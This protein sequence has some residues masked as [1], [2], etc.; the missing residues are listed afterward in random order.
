MRFAI[1][2]DDTNFFTTPGELLA[3]YGAVWDRFPIT[4]SLISR[5]KGNWP[6]WVH[7]IYSQRAKTDWTA[8]LADDTA[9]PIGDNRELVDFLKDGLAQGCVDLAF[10]ARHHRNAEPDDWSPL[11]D[12]YIQGAEF[13]VKS[14][15]S[16]VLRQEVDYLNALFGYSINVFTPPQNILSQVGYESVIRADL[17]LCGGCIPFYRKE[18]SRAGLLNL[19]RQIAFRIKHPGTDY[20]YVLRYSHHSEIIH[21]YP[22]QPTTR[23]ESLVAAFERAR[24]FNGDFVLSTHYIEHPYATTYDPFLTMGD[25]FQAFIRHVEQYSCV[26]AMSLSE[27]LSS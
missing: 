5:V 17:N 9:Y 18:K 2:D 3:C 10:H 1:R 26:E 15:Q 24:G 7:T 25:V 23:L 8:W 19:L 21:H 27:L 12:N 22:L 11:K 16:V 6:H 20:P 4:L 14:D 13:Y